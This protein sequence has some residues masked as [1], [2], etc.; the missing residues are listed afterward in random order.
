MY[1]K[2]KIFCSDVV[3][4]VTEYLDIRKIGKFEASFHTTKAGATEIHFLHPLPTFRDFLRQLQFDEKT[5]IYITKDDRLVHLTWEDIDYVCGYVNAGE[6]VR[7]GVISS[8]RM[9]LPQTYDSLCYI[10]TKLGVNYEQN[11][12]KTFVI[13]GVVVN[14]CRGC[15]NCETICTLC[16]SVFK[17]EEKETGYDTG[18]KES[19]IFTDVLPVATNQPILACHDCFTYLKLQ[20]NNISHNEQILKSLNATYGEFF[21]NIA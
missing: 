10:E 12:F 2:T 5:R 13:S 1:L 18:V 9:F 16:G 6:Y 11:V 20:Y 21:F 4:L 14:I 8:L 7:Q 3:N 17:M 19:D 15:V